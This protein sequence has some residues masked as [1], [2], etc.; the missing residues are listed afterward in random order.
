MKI[1]NIVQKTFINVNEAGTEAAAA[2]AGK[3]KHFG[4]HKKKLNLT[5]LPLFI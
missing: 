1:S 2:T 5:Q 4:K 3:L